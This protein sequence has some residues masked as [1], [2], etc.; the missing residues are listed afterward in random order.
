MYHVLCQQKKLGYHHGQRTRD[1]S[2]YDNEE[3]SQM[4]RKIM[5]RSLPEAITMVK[6]MNILSD[7][8]WTDNYRQSA[9]DAIASFLTGRMKEKLRCHLMQAE[10]DGIP[11]RRNGTYIRHLLTEL[12]DVL[13]LVP[14]TRTFN[15]VGIIRAYARRS[16]EVDRLILACFLLG[17]S[18]RKVGEA[19]LAI[20]GDKISPSTVSRV[21]HDLDIAVSAFHKRK[22][23]NIYRALF[24]D[25]VI[26]SRKTG[27]GSMKRPVLVAFG[28]RHDGKKEIIDFRLARSE[29]TNEWESFL[30]NLTSRGLS[31]EGTELIA[32]DGGAGLG[33][34]VRSVYPL[35][36]LQRCWAHKMRN[37]LDKVRKT[38]HKGVKKGL[39]N[40]YTAGSLHKARSAARRWA[41][42]WT[43]SYPAAVRCL[44]QDLEELLTCFL[45]SDPVFR[46]K[47][48]TTNAIER[49]FREVRRRTRPMGV[50]ENRTSMERI[51]YA[52]F[53]YEN[54]RY[55]VHYIFGC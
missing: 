39:V 37:I 35:I 46:K 43:E 16:Q 54:I 10:A 47:V 33:S 14:R 51:L 40:I 44:Q 52:V 13:V 21:A 19:L 22:L 36:P 18:T 6:E 11:D 49:V 45:F 55:G 1:G 31:A 8:E 4:E 20:L 12:G 38:D 17:L 26:L 30:V 23:K 7:D 42:T 34:A 24:F 25:G 5:I 48:R 3:V 27:A 2:I 53:L 41:D 28:I 15:P 50:F 32:V 9:K 29:S